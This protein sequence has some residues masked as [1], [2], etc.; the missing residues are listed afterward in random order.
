[1]SN[2]IE[3]GG[4]GTATA[5]GTLFVDIQFVDVATSQVVPF[6]AQSFTLTG[7]A[8]FSTTASS[9]ELVIT[10]VND[11]NPG[12]YF[13]GGNISFQGSGVVGSLALNLSTTTA[14]VPE[15]ATGVL[16]GAIGLVCLA[17]SRRRLQQAR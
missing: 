17:S 7:Q 10:G 6:G 15:P 5:S 11:Q 1:V 14:V 3:S 4:T 13:G 8:A 9:D 12:I 16:L 2:I